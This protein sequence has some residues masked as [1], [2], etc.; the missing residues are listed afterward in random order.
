MED[1][2]TDVFVVRDVLRE[3]GLDLELRVAEDGQHALRY[4]EQMEGAADT[5]CP[6]MV[7]LD[8][9]LPK[10]G[11]LE[12]L[13]KLR[14]DSRC[15]DVP[16][17][18]VSSSIADSDRSRARELGVQAYFQKPADLSAYAELARIIR[19]TLGLND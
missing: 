9:N 5:P 8:L 10:I 6:A 7:L 1:N 14:G 11:G 17:V 18:V 16:V 2:P 12:V 3:Y 4:I 13:R 15:H 19:E